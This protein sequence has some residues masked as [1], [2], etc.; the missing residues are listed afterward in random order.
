MRLLL[1]V[2]NKAYTL[3]P[4]MS[5]GPSRMESYF[6]VKTFRRILLL[7]I[8]ALQ[9]EGSLNP[10]NSAE[11][12]GAVAPSS[13]LSSGPSSRASRGGGPCDA[14]TTPSRHHLCV[15]GGQWWL[16]VHT[17]CSDRLQRS[18]A[19][20]KHYQYR[21]P[22]RALILASGQKTQTSC[23]PRARDTDSQA[24]LG[25]QGRQCHVTRGKHF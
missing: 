18:K 19:S 24:D 6:C 3:C 25:V 2:H 14:G 5:R 12:L 21:A 17:H 4:E 23:W 13:V 22:L 15:I 7:K 1:R 10:V 11:L 20:S 8:I 9:I 16:T